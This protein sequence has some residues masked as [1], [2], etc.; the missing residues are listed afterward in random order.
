MTSAN[1]KKQVKFLGYFL[2][3]LNLS[4]F[5]NPRGMQ[6]LNESWVELTRP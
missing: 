6:G 2:P 5:Q 1:T 4:D 3:G